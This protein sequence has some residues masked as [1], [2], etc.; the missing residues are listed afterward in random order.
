MLLEGPRPG[1]TERL[2]VGPDDCR[3]RNPRL[4]CGRMTGSGQDGS[5][6]ARAGHD[7]THISLTGALGQPEKPMAPLTLVGDVGGGSML[8]VAVR[9]G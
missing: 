1:V 6:V 3:A 9:P 7:V 2:W 5:M 8:L 4:V